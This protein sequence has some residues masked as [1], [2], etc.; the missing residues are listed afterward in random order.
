MHMTLLGCRCRVGAVR[1]GFF[2]DNGMYGASSTLGAQS[3]Y[4]RN[5]LLV[6]PGLEEVGQLTTTHSFRDLDEV[7]RRRRGVA[8]VVGILF[9]DREER[10][11]ADLDSEG[12]ERCPTSHV[13]DEVAKLLRAID[14]ARGRVCSGSVSSQRRGNVS[15]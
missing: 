8:E 3:G 4:L 10:S 2:S 5:C 6:Q 14:T 13:R 9:E 7:V 11:I 1:P 15:A 12:M